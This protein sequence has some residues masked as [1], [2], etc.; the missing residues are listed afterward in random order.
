MNTNAGY[1]FAIGTLIAIGFVVMVVLVD[2]IGRN[3][4]VGLAG[5]LIP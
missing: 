3:L 5:W 4:G 1:R 2:A